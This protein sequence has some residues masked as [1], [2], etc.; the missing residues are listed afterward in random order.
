M[1]AYCR[2]IKLPLNKQ[3]NLEY[4]TQRAKQSFEHFTQE[5]DRIVKGHRDQD[6]ED[7]LVEFV[8]RVQLS[9]MTEA[10]KELIFSQKLSNAFEGKK[11]KEV[12]N[13]FMQKNV[14]NSFIFEK[15]SLAPQHSK[16]S[17]SR[18]PANDRLKLKG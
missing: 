10:E 5:L 17:T 14:R 7:C 4:M 6:F 1:N 12:I 16:M 15:L 9:D 13:S 18:N 11:I 3:Q 2:T 8:N